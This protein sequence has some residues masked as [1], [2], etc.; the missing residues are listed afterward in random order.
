M[1][2]VAYDPNPGA[3]LNIFWPAL[4]HMTFMLCI[5]D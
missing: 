2:V 3:M 5:L 1:S 4:T